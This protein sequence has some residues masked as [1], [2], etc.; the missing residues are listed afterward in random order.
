MHPPS[1]ALV[2][3]RQQLLEALGAEL[4]H[5]GERVVG[6]RDAQRLHALV[7]LLH[8]QVRLAHV[9]DVVVRSDES[10]PLPL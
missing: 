1:V 10:T 9:R 5:P 4:L 6:E 7:G 2:E 8:A 3:H